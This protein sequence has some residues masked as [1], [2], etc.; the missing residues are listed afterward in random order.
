MRWFL[1][2]LLDDPRD[3]IVRV[4]SWRPSLGGHGIEWPTMLIDQLG[5]RRMTV[6]PVWDG[7]MMRHVF[8]G[9]GR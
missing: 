6:S 7:A 5:Y 3:K 1:R 2:R 8:M 9:W 4:K